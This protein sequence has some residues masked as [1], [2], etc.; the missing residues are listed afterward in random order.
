MSARS[1]VIVVGSVNVDLVAT[2][3]RLPAPGETVTGGRFAQHHGGK[4]GNQAVA[5]ARLGAPTAFVGAVG[6]DAFGTEARAALE[7]EG[8]DVS[9][10]RTLPGQATGVA[11]ILVD[12]DGENSIAV[13]GGANA[14]LTPED[15]AASFERLRP[16]TGDVVLVGHEIPTATATEALRLAKASGATTIFNPAPA[17]GV[18]PEALALTD[19]LTPNEGE[20]AQLVGRGGEIRDPRSRPARGP[21]RGRPGAHDARCSRGAADRPGRHAGDPGTGR[22]RRGHR[23]GG[24]HAEWRAGGRARGRPAGRRRCPSRRD[25]RLT[26]CHAGGRARGHADRRASSRLRWRPRRRP[27][28]PDLQRLAR[29]AA[30]VR[31]VSRTPPSVPLSTG[32]SSG[33]GTARDGPTL[34][35][36]ETG[37]MPGFGRP[38]MTIEIGSQEVGRVGRRGRTS[39]AH[40]DADRRG[41][42]E[43]LRLPGVHATPEHRHVPLSAPA[44]PGWSPVSS[45]RGPASSSAS[46]SSAA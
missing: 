45:C 35:R 3:D 13:A 14:A 33:C 31:L 37:P 12:G 28:E 17:T 32:P 41:R 46:A 42:R 18:T 11:L 40:V 1:P 8:V 21:G 26:G 39:A 5:A 7:A 36:D 9:E 38:T 4:G 27:A 16:G 10:L 34:D 43:H 6:D 22:R 2:V 30:Q 25:R 19:L 44:A 23:R 29:T 15:I 24:R 20:A